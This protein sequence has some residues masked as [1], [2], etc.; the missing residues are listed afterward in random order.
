M[1][2]VARKLEKFCHQKLT[3]GKVKEHLFDIIS[4]NKSARHCTTA[5][6]LFQTAQHSHISWKTA[7][8]SQPSR[9]RPASNL[10]HKKNYLHLDIS[11]CCL[12]HFFVV[13]SFDLFS[14][15]LPCSIFEDSISRAAVNLFL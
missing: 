15:G 2:L 7:L 10:G 13:A 1:K 4:R 12:S 11:S 8:Q 14:D 3:F 9:D 5:P 6:A